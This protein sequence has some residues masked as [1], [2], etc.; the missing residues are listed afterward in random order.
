MRSFV[1]ALPGAVLA[2]GVA[3]PA[4][5]AKAPDGPRPMFTRFVRL[6]SNIVQAPGAATPT[7]NFT[8]SYGSSTY[9]EA[10]VGTDPRLGA[11]STTITAYI[12]PVKLTYGSKTEDGSTVIS[13][14]TASPTFQNYP[15]TQGSVAIGNTQFT[16]AFQKANF[17][18]IGGAAAGYHVLLSPVVKPTLV[19]SVPSRQG[20][21]ISNVLGLTSGIL[22]NINWLDKKLQSEIT[23]LGL[24]ANSLPIFVTTQTYLTQSGNSLSGCCIGGYH[25]VT[26]SNGP[27]AHA[28]YIQNA[29]AFAQNVSALSHELAEWIDDP[30]TT[31]Q[32]AC[33]IYEVGDPLERNANYGDYAYTLNGVTYDLQDEANPV[34]FGAPSSTISPLVGSTFVGTSIAVCA[35]GA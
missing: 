30:F 4:V 26:S 2:L 33:G 19:L 20:R 28:T 13:S 27:Y 12:V 17:W 16:D 6:H 10:F 9:T 7:W 23:T 21:V 32:S 18:G 11:A 35:N 14:V 25:S 1:R 29:G 31:N 3:L 5:A 22:V 24:P 8:Y 15:F 34:Y